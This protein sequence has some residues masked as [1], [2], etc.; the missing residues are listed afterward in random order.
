MGNLI[1]QGGRNIERQKEI[2]ALYTGIFYS[3]KDILE[4]QGLLVRDLPFGHRVFNHTAHY[5]RQEVTVKIWA[6]ADLAKANKM[7]VDIQEIGLLEVTKKGPRR[8]E[9]F[10]GTK[11]DEGWKPNVFF[12]GGTDL[13]LGGSRRNNTE[14]VNGYLDVLSQ[15]RSEIRSH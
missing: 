4:K 10:K 2:Q 15:I 5:R 9:E 3:A 8:E 6:R 13:D 11:W 14:L 12:L 7:S 1:E